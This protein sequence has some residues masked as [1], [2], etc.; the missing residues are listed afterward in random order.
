MKS[1]ASKRTLGN[2][3]LTRKYHFRYMGLWIVMA[4][5]LVVVV[6]LLLHLFVTER[7]GGPGAGSGA[8]QEFDFIRKGWGMIMVLEIAFFAVAIVGLAVTTAHR[9]AGPFI[10]LRNVFDAVRDGNVDTRLKFRTE[11]GLEELE[12]AFNAMMDS[13][14]PRLGDEAQEK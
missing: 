3:R 10:R 5:C 7:W 6:N 2:V 13:L 8:Y 12:S 9:I 4:V 1:G 14:K 11:D